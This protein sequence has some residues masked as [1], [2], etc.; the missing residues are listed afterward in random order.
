MKKTMVFKVSMNG[1]KC[2]A[3]AMKIAVSLEGVESAALKGADKSQIE[4]IGDGVDPV[5]LTSLLRKG[6]G[7]TEL[8]SVAEKKEE[9]KDPPKKEEPKKDEPKPPALPHFW[10]PTYVL[11]EAPA[12]GCA[13]PHD[14]NCSIM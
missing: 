7:F 6:V 12:H 4:V 2:R 11:Y 14:S 1:D 10:Y 9:K 3:K 8:V 5:K 13:Q